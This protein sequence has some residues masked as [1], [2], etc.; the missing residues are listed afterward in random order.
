MTLVT[1]LA[2]ALTLFAASLLW[3]ERAAMKAR[4]SERLAAAA[5]PMPSPVTA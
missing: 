1:W 5:A 2:F 4:L 3:R